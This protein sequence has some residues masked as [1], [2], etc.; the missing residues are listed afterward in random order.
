MKIKRILII[1]IGINISTEY[2]DFIDIKLKK[3]IG[4]KLFNR[5]QINVRKSC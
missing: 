2:I 4:D 5:W 1:I 3:D